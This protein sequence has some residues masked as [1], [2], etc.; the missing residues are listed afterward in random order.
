[1][2]IE[3]MEYEA[4]I[5]TGNTEVLKKE[6]GLIEMLFSMLIG[7]SVLHWYSTQRNKSTPPWYKKP[8]HELGNT[9]SGT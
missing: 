7:G 1:M 2:P 6:R 4:Y 5:A 8:S 3:V 9:A